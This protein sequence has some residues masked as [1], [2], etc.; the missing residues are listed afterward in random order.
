M[1][2][3]Q[4]IEQGGTSYNLADASNWWGETLGPHNLRI[5]EAVFCRQRA[6]AQ[7][8]RLQVVISKIEGRYVWFDEKL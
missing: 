1:R 4:W 7:P 6:G 8:Y 5:G 2:V 3:F